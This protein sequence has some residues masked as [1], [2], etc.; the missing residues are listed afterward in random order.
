MSRAVPS[1]AEIARVVKALERASTK[2]ASFKIDAQG[3]IVVTWPDAAVEERGALDARS[4]IIR[5]RLQAQ[6]DG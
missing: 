2:G 3:E 5:K 6:R 4:G 1:Q